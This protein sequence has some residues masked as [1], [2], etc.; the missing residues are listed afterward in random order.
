MRFP[1]DRTA[2]VLQKVTDYLAA[3]TSLVWVIDPE[4][5]AATVYHP[6]GEPV[7][8]GEDGVLDGEDVLPGFTLPLHEVW[9]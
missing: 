4:A 2:E 8:V 1:S 6:V 3:G 7:V 9:V 5:R